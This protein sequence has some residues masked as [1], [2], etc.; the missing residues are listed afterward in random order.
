MAT[1]DP[2]F[3]R[4]SHTKIKKRQNTLTSF[5]VL[6]ESDMTS[7]NERPIRSRNNRC[8][9]AVAAFPKYK[10]ELRPEC[11]LNSRWGRQTTVEIAKNL[12]EAR[13]PH[14]QRV[15]PGQWGGYFRKQRLDMDL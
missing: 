15:Y 12:R 5:Q 13:L 4:N 10:S 7:W 14:Q 1:N 9:M 3:P 2:D 11:V 8:P 6:E